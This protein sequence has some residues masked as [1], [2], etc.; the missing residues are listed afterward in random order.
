MQ[1]HPPSITCR[2]CAPAVS[3]WSLSCL[4][5]WR[6]CSPDAAAA[7]V[8]DLYATVS[9][10]AE[11]PSRPAE[12]RIPKRR[13]QDA[14]RSA[15]VRRRPLQPSRCA[16]RRSLLPGRKPLPIRSLPA[17]SH[18]GS[19]RQGSALH[20]Q[21]AAQSRATAH[22]DACQAA[23]PAGHRTLSGCDRKSCDQARLSL[24]DDGQD[25]NVATFVYT[26]EVGIPER[27]RMAGPGADQAGRQDDCGGA[28]NRHGWANLQR[29]R[30]L[31]RGRH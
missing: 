23:Q 9:S 26:A 7:R 16:D 2:R 24:Q 19:Q 20:R 5:P 29:S 13:W 25:P 11:E 1:L 30:G 22:R 6:L 14:Q 12:E 27:R 21:G 10:A 31:A 28:A 3:S 15:Q 18:A 8:F 4:L 17:R